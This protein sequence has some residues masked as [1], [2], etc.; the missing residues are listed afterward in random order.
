[1]STRMLRYGLIFVLVL[2]VASVGTSQMR[3]GKFGV[4]LAGTGSLLQS[5]FSQTNMKY[6]GGLSLSYSMT[7][8]LGLR[9]TF[10][11][12]QMQFRYDAATSGQLVQG[13]KYLMN[14]FSMNVYLSLDMMPS[15]SVNPFVVAGIGRAYFDGKGIDGIS[16]VTGS[17]WDL[18]MIVGGGFD[19]FMNEFI[20]A[21]VMGEYVVTGTDYLDGYKNGTAND[22]YARIG[23]QVRYYFFDEGFLTQMLE[24]LKDRYKG[25]GKK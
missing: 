22:S 23:L 11:M 4:G 15:S 21:T 1:M 7:E 5:D 8:Y 16:D 14:V 6:G 20:S 25:K 12:D 24:A 2:L 18:H 9:S 3:S 17:S 19:V 13:S 10:L